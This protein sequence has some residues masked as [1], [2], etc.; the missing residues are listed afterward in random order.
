[1]KAKSD[2][3]KGRWFSSSTKRL[4]TI[5]YDNQVFYYARGETKAGSKIK[6][7]VPIAFADILGASHSRAPNSSRFGFVVEAKG[8]GFKLSAA[9]E[10]EAELW[11]AAFLGARN[12]AEARGTPCDNAD[13]TST[14]AG[15]HSSNSTSSTPSQGSMSP[16][17]VD[18]LRYAADAVDC[19][20]D[21]AFS[22][23]PLIVS[24]LAA[25]SAHARPDP[26][27]ALSAL[28]ELAGPAPAHSV[29]AD[30]VGSSVSNKRLREARLLFTAGV[31]PSSLSRP[32]WGE[33]GC[34][35]AMRDRNSEE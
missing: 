1:V 23:P 27:A 12:K 8:H 26:F 10:W 15:S 18:V 6:T 20:P 2:G 5:D 25:P 22:P 24:R 17:P 11:V 4:F 21:I 19:E 16:G 31:K 30:A 13:D 35:E 33:D 14:T 29:A 32:W 28:E 3:A 9:S 7:S 34:E